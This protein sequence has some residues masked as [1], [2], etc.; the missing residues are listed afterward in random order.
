MNTQEI[1]QAVDQG[2]VVCWS[3]SGYTVIKNN[4]RYLIKHKHSFIGLTSL[5][6]ETLNGKESEFYIEG[7]L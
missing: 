6:G 4:E 5:D 3:N 7:A 1:K 2:L